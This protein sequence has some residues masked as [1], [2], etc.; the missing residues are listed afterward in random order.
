[1]EETKE[2]V[3][4]KQDFHEKIIKSTEEAIESLVEDGIQPSDVEML[5]KLVD[6]HKDIC[7]EKY[8]KR[9]ENMYMNYGNY[10]NYNR[11]NY[12]GN[13]NAY[14]EYNRGYGEYNDEYNARGRDSK[15]RGYGHLDRMYNE[16]GNYN[17]GR[18]R[19]GANEDTKKS[20][21]Y[22]LRSMEDFARMLKE[23]AQSQEEVNM[24][25]QTAQRIAQ[26]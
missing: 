5:D 1:M 16:Y 23:E 25:K 17:Y 20:L 9:K 2:E 24:I 11:G 8:W 3:K 22:M 13:Y 4:E 7:E 21:E 15:Y 14:G 6:I 10:G 12:N 19:Y 26:M 18:E